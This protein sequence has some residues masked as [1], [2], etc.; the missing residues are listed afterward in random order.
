MSLTNLQQIAM[1]VNPQ[2][3]VEVAFTS[4]LTASN[5]KYLVI[6]PSLA[7]TPDLYERRI[8]RA[9]HT[10][11]A[12]LTGAKRGTA[13]F[14]LEMAAEADAIVSSPLFDLPLQACGWMSVGCTR[15]TIDGAIVGGPFLHGELLTFSGG[16]TRVN[17]GDLYT[18]MTTMFATNTNGLGNST[19]IGTTDTVTGGTSGAT[20]TLSNRVI[21]K[22]R[23]WWPWSDAIS[24]ITFDATGLEVLNTLAVGDLLRG[25]TSGALARVY[26]AWTGDGTPPTPNAVVYVRMVK[27]HFS[28]A[29][30]VQRIA[31]TAEADIGNLH[32]STFEE[33]VAVPT[34]DIAMLK[35]GV[36][37]A[38][39]GCR[40]TV[41][42]QGNSGEPMIMTFEF[43]GRQH[44]ES[45]SDLSNI[46]S[47]AVT[48]RVPPVLLG[49]AMTVGRN[50]VDTFAQEVTPCVAQIA[51]NQNNS[52]AFRRC[53]SSS[54]GLLEALV[55]GRDMGGTLDPEL[56]SEVVFPYVGQQLDNLDS[57][58]RMNI[59]TAI[60]DKFELRLHHL[61]IR[62]LADGDRDGL[63]TRQVSYALTSGS[64]N[65]GA[66]DNECVLIW[67]V[68]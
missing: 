12:P 11:L 35:D 40:G 28:T 46:P 48:T 57:R 22:A 6:E 10:K 37:E 44:S 17:V 55:T 18:G 16:A 47:V 31:P 36:V 49:T 45:P 34:V 9:S 7:V 54:T 21:N 56:D 38:L 65:A 4:L 26:F 3:N 13:R 19:A 30:V 15:C 2:Q 8:K 24:K 52:V 60:P 29:E 62:T 53:M 14:S 61:A 25:V 66:G 27:G 23:A 63:A 20:A 1:A 33:Q 42:M 32:A 68:T 39:T 41:S 5:A 50:G 43:T 67:E 51:L 59:G 58:L 64:S